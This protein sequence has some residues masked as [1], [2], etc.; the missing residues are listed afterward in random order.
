MV[1]STPLRAGLA[2]AVDTWYRAGDW[3]QQWQTLA[4]CV[5][6]LA[7][8]GKDE[9][10]AEVTGAVERRAALG[11]PPVTAPLRE[12][13][14]AAAEALRTRLGAERYDQLHAEGGGAP[15]ID[16]VHRTRAVLLG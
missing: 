4:L 7:A 9:L 12:R 2:E 1:S 10:A 3:S 5:V 15:V 14:L 16:V 8:A 11:S 6:A 13:T